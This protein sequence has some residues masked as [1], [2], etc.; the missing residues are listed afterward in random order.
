MR[1]WL[2][3]AEPNHQFSERDE[4][5]LSPEGGIDPFIEVVE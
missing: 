5:S 3:A 1:K 2:G 4:R